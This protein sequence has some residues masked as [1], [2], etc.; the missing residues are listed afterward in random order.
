MTR[1]RIHSVKIA[2]FLLLA[3]ITLAFSVPSFALHALK[4]EALKDF[5]VPDLTA[6]NFKECSVSFEAPVVKRIGPAA[7]STLGDVLG[8][9]V[10][11]AEDRFARA[12][13][14]PSGAQND[15]LNH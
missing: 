6:D 10:D 2:F 3:V 5:K 13:D 4:D 12:R 1:H 9:D 11:G 7:F 14:I 8:R 15:S